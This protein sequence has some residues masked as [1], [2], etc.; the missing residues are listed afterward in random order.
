MAHGSAQR[1][2]NKLHT[3][4]S[5]VYSTLSQ[6]HIALGQYSPGQGMAIADPLGKS[7]KWPNR[8]TH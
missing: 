8:I 2:C 7:R 6:L 1:S 5:L 4:N 3:L